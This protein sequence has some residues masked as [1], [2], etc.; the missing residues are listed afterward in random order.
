V[1]HL[2][3]EEIALFVDGRFD[4]IDDQRVAGHIRDCESCRAEYQEAVR[5]K[6][7]WIADKEGFRPPGDFVK[8][9]MAVAASP[10]QVERRGGGFRA[11][12]RLAGV[13][14]AAVVAV[15]A[16]VWLT[17]EKG[18]GGGEGTIIDQVVEP[19]FRAATVI[20]SKTDFVLPRTE[21]VFRP[22]FPVYR[23]GLATDSDSLTSALIYLVDRKN[24]GQA[25]RDDL[26]WL[27]T[28]FVAADQLDEAET[29]VN[30]ALRDYAGDGE[31][32]TLAAVIACFKGDCDRAERLLREVLRNNPGD[33]IARL[34]LAVV[35][36]KKGNRL[37][38]EEHIQRVRH[39]QPKSLIAERA[40]LLLQ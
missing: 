6:G 28:G 39:D 13:A 32:L 31:F 1:K 5:G 35:L 19:V 37:E 34:D 10:M 25:T 23:S 40:E 15:V 36:I 12:V 16:A 38:A 7:R 26:F 21:N 33:P 17:V 29:C 24:A 22:D 30:D 4:G 14:A 8:V 11:V 27:V 20:S 3:E 2:T 18:G 9:G